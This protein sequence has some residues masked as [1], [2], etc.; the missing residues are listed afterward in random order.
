MIFSENDISFGGF[1]STQ[2]LV[3]IVKISPVIGRD[4]TVEN[5]QPVDRL[6]HIIFFKNLKM[7]INQKAK[8]L[9]IFECD[10]Y[11]PFL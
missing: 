6:K 10:L 9:V 11:N 5:T 2:Y 3:A 7:R 8:F 4:Y 1:V